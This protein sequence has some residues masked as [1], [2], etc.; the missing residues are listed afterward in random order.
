VRRLT[1]RI[2]RITS[3]ESLAVA[4][5]IRDELAVD[6]DVELVRFVGRRELL[7]GLLTDKVDVG[8][9]YAANLLRALD[10]AATAL[11]ST[12]STLTQLTRR[13]QSLGV[14]IAATTEWRAVPALV[15]WQSRAR[16]MGITSLAELVAAAGRL[17]AGGPPKAPE[18][19]W[20]MV[21]VE[22]PARFASYTALDLAGDLTTLAMARDDVDV[23]LTY[24]TDPRIAN[25]ETLTF[26]APDTATHADNIVV[27]VRAGFPGH[28]IVIDR[29][30]T[31]LKRMT[32]QAV[33]AKAAG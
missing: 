11:G 33:V 20:R 2:G 21:G 26:T 10:P 22:S 17:R 29:V 14:L 18:E 31:V 24:A 25:S 32:P 3:A 13:L 6:H 4:E 19:M 23:V 30:R 9:D 7:R 15:M 8:Q 28:A 5:L 1:I 12:H 16:E 27:M